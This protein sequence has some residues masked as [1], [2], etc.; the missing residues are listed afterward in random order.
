M[1]WK[2]LTYD[3]C[4][5]LQGGSP[6]CDGTTWPVKLPTVPLDRSGSKCGVAGGWHFC[7]NIET[8]LKIG[9]MWPTGR[10]SAVVAVDPHG[11]VIERGDKCRAA[12]LTLVRLATEDEVAQAIHR[13]SAVF[14]PHGGVMA[15]EQISWR[16]ALA[17]PDHDPACVERQL[18]IAL[19]A[20]GLSG[21][22]LRRFETQQAER[23]WEAWAARAARAA[24]EALTYKFAA[25]QHWLETDADLLTIGIRDAYSYGLEIALPSGP[26]ELG[27]AMKGGA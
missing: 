12:S 19:D 14:A 25:L 27:W 24:Q 18:Q 1:C 2:V 10:P 17:R 22:S 5:P 4:P 9:G 3:F 23:A 15:A 16:S 26:T 7:R 13:F 6:L 8:A 20:R 21:W 11:D